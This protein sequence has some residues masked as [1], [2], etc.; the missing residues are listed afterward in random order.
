MQ[1]KT[2]TQVYTPP[3][4]LLFSVEVKSALTTSTYQ[5]EEASLE[6]YE[7]IDLFE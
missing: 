3:K 6:D 5:S 7:A 1:K 2:E 4:M